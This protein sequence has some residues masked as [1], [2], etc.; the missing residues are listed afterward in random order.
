MASLSWATLAYDRRT[1]F[2]PPTLCFLLAGSIPAAC[3]ERISTHA[4][5]RIVFGA[6]RRTAVVLLLVLLILLRL[7]LVQLL[8][9]L[10]VRRN[11]LDDPK[12]ELLHLERVLDLLGR[13]DVLGGRGGVA[14]AHERHRARERNVWG[15]RGVKVGQ[16]GLVFKNVV[17]KGEEG[18]CTRSRGHAV[19]RVLVGWAAAA[20]RGQTHSEG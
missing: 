7:A 18:G 15:R 10:H 20:G 13:I 5:S 8:L 16:E 14:L 2:R 12:P 11:G 3:R 6:G 4:H 1:L 19:E 9:A 17:D